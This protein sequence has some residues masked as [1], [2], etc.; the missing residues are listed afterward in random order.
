MEIGEIKPEFS[1]LI[2]R[3]NVLARDVVGFIVA[4]ITLMHGLSV[5]RSA[6][7]PALLRLYHCQ[8]LFMLA[9]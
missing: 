1:A 5:I 6:K 9:R 4:L 2:L 8:E 7:E 3:F